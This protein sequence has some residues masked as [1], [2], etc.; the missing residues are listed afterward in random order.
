MKC[1]VVGW[2][3]AVAAVVVGDVRASDDGVRKRFVG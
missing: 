1:V 3:V 2:A